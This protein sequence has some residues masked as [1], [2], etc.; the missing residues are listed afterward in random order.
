[1]TAGERRLSGVAGSDGVVV[2]PV[3]RLIDVE[4]PVE[5][6]GGPAEQARARAALQ[7]VATLLGEASRRLRAA[8]RT[9]EA[10]IVETS[11]LMAE[12][13]SLQAEVEA[14]AESRPAI[15]ALLEA[16]ERQAALLAALPD[17][18]LAARAA[19]VRRLGRQ[20]ARAAGEAPPPDPLPSLPWGRCAARI[21]PTTGPRPSGFPVTSAAPP[22]HGTAVERW[23]PPASRGVLPSPAAGREAAGEGLRVI[24]VARDLGPADLAEVELNG[25]AIGGI[26]LAEGS[27]TSHA[28][29]VARSLGVPLVVGLDA[30]LLAVPDSVTAVLDGTAGV[31]VISPATPTLDQ[32]WATIARQEQRQARLALSRDDGAVT[33]DG[34]PIRLLVNASTEREVLAGLAAGAG[35]VGLLR[36]EL[37]FLDVVHWPTVAQHEAA[38]RPIFRHLAGRIV[39]VRTLDFGADKIPPFLRGRV[40]RGVALQLLALGNDPVAPPSSGP[41][42]GAAPEPSAMEAQLRA[43]PRA[44]AEAGAG[45]GLRVMLPLVEQAEQVDA[46]RRSLHAAYRAVG[47]ETALPPLGAM[48]ETRRAVEQI[49][50]I[51]ATADFLSIG[52]NDLVHDLLGLDRLTPAAT[53]RSA[54]DPRLL[55]AVST[56]TAAA[57]R[58]HRTVEVCGEAAGDPRIAVLLIGLGVSELSVAPS[59]L[60]EVRAAVRAVTL[61]EAAHL[62][63]AAAALD[64]ADAV[65]ALLDAGPAE[66][67]QA[68]GLSS[69]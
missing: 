63:E 10:E 36:T 52:T 45:S 58:H 60:D 11:R 5:G 32:A 8:G 69:E 2:G 33:A 51:A 21:T 46:A 30:D 44:W 41:A 49:D 39:T 62:A 24:L 19:D 29:I 42:G 17:P 7:R 13:P 53:I 4:I 48:V 12:D 31:L 16:T 28:A 18:Y 64:S 3:H 56:V 40:E 22:P 20:A 43:L 38:L 9:D 54:A 15:A 59:R 6:A 26:A 57:R 23:S 1:M 34:H 67:L 61:A 55:R 25:L 14:L 50:G 65:L 68:D 66:R 27:V 35:G 47:L 37:A